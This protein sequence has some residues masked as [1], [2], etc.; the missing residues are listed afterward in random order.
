MEFNLNEKNTSTHQ[1]KHIPFYVS[2][3]ELIICF[4]IAILIFI[5]YQQTLSF[6]F[7]WDDNQHIVTNTNIHSGLTRDGIKWAFKVQNGLTYWHPLTWVSHML[8]IQLFGLNPAGHHLSNVLLHTANSLLLFFILQLLT[9]SL[10]RSTLVAILFALHPLNIESVA[11]IAERKN[12]LSSFFWLL[13]I[14]AYYWYSLKPKYYSYMFVLLLFIMGLLSKPALVVLPAILLLLDFWPINRYGINYA[15]DDFKIGH[16]ISSPYKNKIILLFL[17][18]I[19]LFLLSGACYF[20][21]SA[22]MLETSTE[23]SQFVT[24]ELIPM[25]I[26]LENIPVS[27][28]KYLIK[29]FWPLNLGCFYPF[30]T[31]LPYWQVTGAII[32]LLLITLLTL[33]YFPGKPYLLIGWF[34]FCISLIPVSGIVQ[35]GMWPALADRWAYIP[36]I[37]LFIIFSWGICDLL[38]KCHTLKFVLI[39]FVLSTYYMTLTMHQVQYWKDEVT[40]Y[41]RAIEVTDKN[42]MHMRKNLSTVIT[43]QG[44]KL[45][46]EGK[47]DESIDKFADAILIFPENGNSYNGLGVTLSLKG[48]NDIAKSY[49]Q[50]ALAINPDF[51][52]AHMNLGTLFMVSKEYDEALIHFKEAVRLKPNNKLAIKN[53]EKALSIIDK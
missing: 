41:S 26:R 49:F 34:L 30:P 1:K 40:L 48:K 11:W 43:T 46:L 14:L 15:A 37:G 6:D 47:L 28:V 45:Q 39:T 42:N 20:L 53:L 12:V 13:T 50:K 35:A 5:A 4:I 16:L 44:S 21:A 7:V 38:P 23:K 19:P 17:E 52:E 51:I 8:D 2:H 3:P 29:F 18:K 24:N 27:Y 33:R 25:T 10:W 36:Y 32:I 31:F 9:G 22:S